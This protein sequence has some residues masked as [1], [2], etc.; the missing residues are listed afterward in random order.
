MATPRG[1]RRGGL[2]QDVLTCLAAAER[3][4]S[5][6]EV[7]AELGGDLAY[8]TV[9]TTLARLHAKGVLTRAPHGRGYVYELPG[10]LGEVAASVSAHQMRRILEGGQDRAGILARFVSDLSPEDERVLLALLSEEK[11]DPEG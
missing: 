3:P 1:R 6:A 9:M 11:T 10:A 5:P 7:L 4:L 2:E 8:T